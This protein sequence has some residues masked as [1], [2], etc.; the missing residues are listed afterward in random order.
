MSESLDAVWK[1][2]ADPTRRGLLDLL[3]GQP[4]TTGDLCAAFAPALSRFA[5]MKHLAVLEQA[6]LVVPR[7]RGRQVWHHLNAVPLRRIYER[8]V[9]AYESAWAASLVRLQETSEARPGGEQSGAEETMEGAQHPQ[10]PQTLRIEQ[11]VEIA[12]APE[13]VF[14]AL[15]AQIGAWWSRHFSPAPRA[16]ALEPWPG[17]RLYEEFGGGA[18]DAGVTGGALYATVT[19][20]ER[21]R[22]LAL[23]GALG[24]PGPVLGVVTFDLEP[25]AGGGATLVRLSHHAIGAV[26]AD[27]QDRYGAGWGALLRDRLKRFVEEGVRYQPGA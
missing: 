27:T 20:L 16:I 2:L 5:V 10:A 14:D 4:R 15:T 13:R 9:G 12:A 24:M 23:T 26:D 3:R 6:G 21:G 11:E 25:R 18:G 19:Y 17:G 1:A 7:R 22:R 8:W